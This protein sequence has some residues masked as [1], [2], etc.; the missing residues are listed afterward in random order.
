[1]KKKKLRLSKERIRVLTDAQL[2]LGAGAGQ[3]WSCVQT[4]CNINPPPPPY[5]QNDGCPI[6][7]PPIPPPPPSFGPPAQCWP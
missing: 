1:M 4:G 2:A 7:L 6:I 5:S 3:T